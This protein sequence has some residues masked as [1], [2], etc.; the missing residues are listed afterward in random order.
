[1]E[2]KV[3]EAVYIGLLYQVYGKL[4]TPRQQTLVQSYYYDDLSLG[5]IGEN[6]QISR[7]AVSGQIRKAV[8]RMREM[9]KD[10]HI[11]A[12]Q[13]K[14]SQA[15]QELLVLLDQ[16]DPEA[17]TRAKELLHGLA[18]ELTLLTEG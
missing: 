17:M 2:G 16:P 13:E 9:E 5:E 12:D 1:M 8:D 18:S 6:L 4:L 15:I 3:E 14:L 11:L 10:L 7:Q